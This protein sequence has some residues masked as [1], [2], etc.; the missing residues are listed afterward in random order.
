MQDY[1]RNVEESWRPVIGH[2]GRYEVSNLGRVRS[3]L[4]NKILKQS[5]K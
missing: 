4:T 5:K 1:S 3:L 2:E